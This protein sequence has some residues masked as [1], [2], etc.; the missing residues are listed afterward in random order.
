MTEERSAKIS[1]FIEQAQ[2]VLDWNMMKYAG[3]ML[4]FADQKEIDNQV[5]YTKS[6]AQEII[7][8]INDRNAR[9]VLDGVCDTFVTATF[10]IP[11][12]RKIREDIG[13]HAKLL[14][15]TRHAESW[16]GSLPTLDKH[17]VKQLLEKLAISVI[18][19][20]SD[21][22]STMKLCYLLDVLGIDVLGAI[23]SV[24]KS[25]WSKYPLESALK[26]HADDECRWIEANRNVTDVC[27]ITFSSCLIF[28]SQMGEGKIMKPS[29]FEDPVF[30]EQDVSFLEKILF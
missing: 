16:A 27:H 25:N 4:P 30:N 29:T 9:E 3:G 15:A 6:E 12:T 23:E 28:R 18:T 14:K 1:A 24:M 21:I 26:R 5:V 22:V 20:A 2:S 17:G 7:D 13:D 10:M 8:G 11:L 19:D